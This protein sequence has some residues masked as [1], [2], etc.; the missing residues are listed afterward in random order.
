LVAILHAVCALA[1]R[2]GGGPLVV[3]LQS[4]KSGRMLLVHGS[5]GAGFAAS[6]PDRA[7]PLHAALRPAAK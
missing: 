3:K 4:E 7:V 1:D 6:V 5:D 2:L